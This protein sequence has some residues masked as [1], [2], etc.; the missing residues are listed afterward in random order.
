[1]LIDS[2]KIRIVTVTFEVDNLFDIKP[3]QFVTWVE[4]YSLQR[5]NSIYWDWGRVRPLLFMHPTKSFTNPFPAF[6]RTVQRYTLFLKKARFW[7]T[8]SIKQLYL[9]YL[10]AHSVPLLFRFHFGVV[11]SL[12]SPRDILRES[13]RQTTRVPAPSYTSPFAVGTQVLLRKNSTRTT[14][15]SYKS[16]KTKDLR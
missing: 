6:G 16:I 10:N 3:Y 7:I 2:N 1:M 13:A 9:A 5:H 8:K 15:F 4:V 11:S 14:S 12:S